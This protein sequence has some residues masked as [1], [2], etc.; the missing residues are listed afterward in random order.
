MRNLDQFERER[1]KLLKSLIDRAQKASNSRS[2]DSIV[3][4]IVLVILRSRPICRQFNGTSLTGVYREIYDLVKQQL[5]QQIRQKLIDSNF[6]SKLDNKS[7]K[8]KKLN[9]ERL[10][11]MQ[12]QIFRQVINDT[13]LKK[14]AL[15]ARQYLPN[16]E[17]RAYAL[18]ELIKAIKL[19]G[20]LCRPHAQ[21]FS[22]ALYQILYEE[23]LTETFVYICLNIDLY[24][25]ERG[26][27]KFMNWVNFK[28]DK[29]LLDCY[30]QYSQYSQQK[31]PSFQNL[32]QIAQAP[33]TPRLPELIH[34]Y[35]QR[36][37]DRIFRKTHI[38]NRPDANFSRIAL[39][40]FEGQSW[41]EIASGLD[42]SISTI[43]NFYYRWCRRFAPL[44]E[45]ELKKHV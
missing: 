38:R 27:K 40:R 30:E 33:K 21:K 24:D 6:Q 13:Y 11:Q 20:R 25:P 26:D 39:A 41:Q 23:A 44:L 14:L 37:P 17:L 4:K 32:E 2:Q 35:I 22:P 3:S 36:D 45:A 10:Y 16:S 15:T 31:L 34:Q 42:I 9:P 1:H 8:P 5:Q 7:S 43:S 29:F 28:L 12:T 18:T 19:S